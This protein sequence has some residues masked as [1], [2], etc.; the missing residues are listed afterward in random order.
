MNQ[1]RELNKIYN[2]ITIHLDR[3]CLN[4]N[5]YEECIHLLEI[6]DRIQEL[7]LKRIIKIEKGG[8]YER[9]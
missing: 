2:K 7:L 3:I 1:I 8:N 4:P 9:L 5:K 6:Q